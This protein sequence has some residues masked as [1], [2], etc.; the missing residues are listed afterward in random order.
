MDRDDVRQMFEHAT[1]LGPKEKMNTMVGHTD[2]TIVIM[3][4][5]STNRVQMGVDGAMHLAMVLLMEC[6]SV[7][8]LQAE[9]AE[10]RKLVT[11][12]MGS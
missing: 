9:K 8:Q 7:R 12:A 2:N 3:H 1:N 10:Q 11:A 6:L 4:K 5:E